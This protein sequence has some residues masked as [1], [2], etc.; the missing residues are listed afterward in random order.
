MQ[1]LSNTSNPD[2][3]FT[4]W[5]AGGGYLFRD[6]LLLSADFRNREGRWTDVVLHG[7]AEI[8]FFN[9]LA[10]RTGLDRGMVTIGAG[11]QDKMW[12]ADISLETDNNLGNIYMLSFTVRN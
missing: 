11:L 2:P 3:V 5:A 12:Q 10:L 4:E 7:G 8:W 9:A 6:T 1:L